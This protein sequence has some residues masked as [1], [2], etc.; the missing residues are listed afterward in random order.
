MIGELDKNQ[1]G[2]AWFGAVGKNLLENPYNQNA[3]HQVLS[4]KLPLRCFQRLLPKALQQAKR[5][6]K[7]SSQRIRMCVFVTIC[8][9]C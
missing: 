6:K 8:F 4:R 3:S 2:G 7:N 1:S 5:K 9:G